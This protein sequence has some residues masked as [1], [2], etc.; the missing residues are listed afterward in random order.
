MK[1]TLLS[2]NKPTNIFNIL[3]KINW[4]LGDINTIF[5]WWRKKYLNHLFN[6]GNFPQFIFISF[7]FNHRLSKEGTVIFFHAI[8]KLFKGEKGFWWGMVFRNKMHFELQIIQ[9]I[10]LVASG[11]L[12][13]PV[14]ATVLFT[15]GF[16]RYS[17]W[18]HR[19]N[20][21]SPNIH[22]TCSISVQKY[23]SK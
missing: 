19:G 23:I 21:L 18:P 5:K 7:L 15:A 16:L 13:E 1:Y 12:E 20:S 2:Y 4:E 10:F 8:K 14:G 17:N 22:G 6:L 3:N 9:S 11:I